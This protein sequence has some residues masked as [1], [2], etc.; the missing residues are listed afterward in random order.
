MKAFR[1]GRKPM[2][3]HLVD[4][5]E[6]SPK[7]KARL[8]GILDAMA[9]ERTIPEICKELGICPSRFHAMRQEL[10]RVALAGLEPKPIGR[11]ANLAN[12]DFEQVKRLEEQNHQ[13]HLQLEAT[14]A[15]MALGQDLSDLSLLGRRSK[16]ASP[17]SR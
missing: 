12:V 2:G 15:R 8:K 10:L 13:L 4:E 14:R 1:R 7:A 9:G 17:P 5:L 6:G 16:K 3:S 11:P